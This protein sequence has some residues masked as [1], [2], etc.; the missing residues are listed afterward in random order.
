[1]GEGARELIVVTPLDGNWTAQHAGVSF[2]A[3]SLASLE[4]KMKADFPSLDRVQFVPADK[5]ARS[6]VARV[7]QLQE[8]ARLAKE[9]LDAARGACL[10]KLAVDYGMSVRDIATVVGG[11]S[12]GRVAT[13]LLEEKARVGLAEDKA[14]GS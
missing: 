6:L 11:I 2:E 12:H 7:Q 5:S 10:L 4:T 3:S 8:E 9:R 13:I 14:D 1:M